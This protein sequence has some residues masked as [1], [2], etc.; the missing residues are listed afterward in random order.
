ML[1][2]NDDLG[3]L[4]AETAAAMRDLART[5]TDAPPLRLTA[6]ATGLSPVRPRRRPRGPRFRWSW[7]APLLAAVTVVAFAVTLVI[8]RNL[9]Q[10]QTAQPASATSAATASL[11]ATAPAPAESGLPEY[12]VAL[13]PASGRTGAPNGLVV[14]DTRTGTTVTVIAPPADSTFVSVSGAADDRTFAVAAAPTA[15]GPGLDTGFYLVAITPGST[16]G[17]RLTQIPMEPLPGVIATALSASGQE[18]AV[19]TANRAVTG[20]PVIRELTVYSVATGRP[21]RS[22]STGNTSAIVS[23]AMPGVHFG[24]YADQYPALSWVDADKVVEFP[25]FAKVGSPYSGYVVQVL[26]VSVTAAGGDLMVESKDLASFTGLDAPPC[27]TFFPVLSGNG[28]TLF[29]LESS[30][31]EGHT[32][33]ST[34]R[35][36]LTW[37]PRATSLANGEEFRNFPYI[38]VIGVPTGSA[39]SLATAWAS[40]T[41]STALIEWSVAAPGAAGGHGT[42]V[43][44]GELTST[45]DGWTFTPLPA[46][47]IFATGGLPGIAW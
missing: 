30:G 42:S 20:G 32:N 36:Q 28:T 18:L 8:V 40:S 12:Y 46:P 2:E 47:A 14:G 5:V 6:E 17:A 21:S 1:N 16:P 9:P 35:W 39:V 27:G 29:C 3:W 23:D 25:V 43:R 19:A 4:S 34:V 10:E 44:F 24:A 11:S 45:E 41:G 37:Q 31:P 26:G 15:G 38:K 7:G 22:W 13:H 33:P